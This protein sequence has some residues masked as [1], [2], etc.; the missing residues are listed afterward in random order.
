ML[1]AINTA[2]TEAFLFARPLLSDVPI[3]AKLSTVRDLY[4][5]NN[6]S[7]Y[8]NCARYEGIHSSTNQREDS[9]HERLNGLNV[10]S[11]HAITP[12]IHVSERIYYYK[13]Q[14]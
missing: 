6:G 8:Q 13:E 10:L 11:V 12:W 14:V 9:R 4:S 3:A 7:N 5:N 1:I 2:V